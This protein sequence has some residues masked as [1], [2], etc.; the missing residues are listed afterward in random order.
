MSDEKEIM[1]AAPENTEENAV[2]RDFS[3]P[4]H[5]KA[6]E[7]NAKAP[8]DTKAKGDKDAAITPDAPKAPFEQAPTSASPADGIK[9][10]K[11]KTAREKKAGSDSP[12]LSALKLGG[13]LFLVTAIMAVMLSTVNEMTKGPI[14][15]NDRMTLA[16]TISAMFPG[17]TS[18]EQKDV[19]EEFQKDIKAIYV[20][21]S[22]NGGVCI[23]AAPNGF[24]GE[25]DMLIG[26]HVDGS[27]ASVKI[28][29]MSETAGIGTK[30]QDVSFLSQYEG[31]RA[32]IELGGGSDQGINAISG[33]T[34]SSKAVTLGVNNAIAVYKAL[35]GGTDAG[36]LDENAD[37][38]ASDNASNTTAK[39]GDTAGNAQ[40]TA[41]GNE[42]NASGETE[43]GGEA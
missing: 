24:G 42:D 9:P 37:A 18:Y 23:E 12:I 6:Q 26:F 4:D 15:D 3:P 31:K 34:I 41:A 36:L 11:K 17:S 20:V 43:D 40:N 8:S 35:Y 1:G 33:A 19:P 16:T 39:A 22:D 27:I 32:H 10:E 29:S 30:T 14:A 7:E 13:I 38:N 25:I 21:N 2:N 28:L 5:E